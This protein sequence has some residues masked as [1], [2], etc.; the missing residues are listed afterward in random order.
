MRILNL[1]LYSDDE[2]YNKMK[3]CL[4]E[5]YDK[6]DFV[7]TIYYKYNNDISDDYLL[8]DNV[9]N[10]KGKETY[11]PGILDKTIKA[12]EYIVN[13]GIINDYDYIFR[14]N[15]STIVNFNLLKNQMLNIQMYGGV[16]VMRLTW[17]HPEAG[18]IDHRW[19]G[20][21]FVSGTCIIF[22][23]EAIKYIIDYQHLLERNVI[24]DVAFGILFTKYLRLKPTSYPAEKW[25]INRMFV[26]DDRNKYLF[27][28]NAR[29]KNNRDFDVKNMRRTVECL[30]KYY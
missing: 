3:E 20:T 4:K 22:R 21:Y 1:V 28:R 9:L 30:I 19:D 8:K 15:I 10:I 2:T 12:F 14:T 25:S 11:I 27:F 23:K 18:I 13:E 16:N 5:Y 26:E 6:I 17:L 24:D 29:N 7:K